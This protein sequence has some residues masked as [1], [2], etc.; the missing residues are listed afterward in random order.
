M[1]G[2]DGIED[3]QQSKGECAIFVRLGCRSGSDIIVAQPEEC[4]AVRNGERG[5][6]AKER[7]CVDRYDHE[8]WFKLVDIDV[9]LSGRQMISI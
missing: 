8:A 5:Y 7:M 9:E 3:R 4:S 6:K 2:C 1:D